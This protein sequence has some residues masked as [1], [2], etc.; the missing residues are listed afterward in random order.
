[1]LRRSQWSQLCEAL[2]IYESI[3]VNILVISVAI[4]VVIYFL[5]FMLCLKFDR[6]TRP[7]KV[8]L[9]MYL[10]IVPLE[11][12]TKLWPTKIMYILFQGPPWLL[13]QDWSEFRRQLIWSIFVTYDSLKSYGVVL[14]PQTLE[15]DLTSTWAPCVSILSNMQFPWN[16]STCT[17]RWSLCASSRWAD[18]SP[19]LPAPCQ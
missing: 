6:E 18:M 15:E 19:S 2:W 9:E 16:L 14:L 5:D 13:L 17:H 7:R 11:R 3:K 10:E 8:H 1:M 4:E 12:D